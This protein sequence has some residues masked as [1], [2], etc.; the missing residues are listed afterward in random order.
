MLKISV[1][2]PF[3][4]RVDWLAEAV[5]SVLQQEY[6]HI[7][8]IVINDGSPEDVSE[9]LQRY[10]DK[11]R[12]EKKENGGPSTARNRGIEMATGD[13]IAFL[14]S[15]DIWL[16]NKLSV[17]VS[18][19]VAHD[20]TW[21]YCGYSTFG[22]GN[23]KKYDMTNENCANMQRYCVPYIATPCVMIRREYL[24]KHPECRFNPKLRYGQD[25]YMWLTMNAD[26]SILAIPEN[27]VKVR[28]RGTNAAK[29]ARVQLQAR[30][31]IWK[32]RKLEK[33]KLIKKF[34]ISLL[35]A[36]ASELCIF[37]SFIVTKMSQVIKSEEILEFVSKIFFVLPWFIF[38]VDRLI[39]KR[40]SISC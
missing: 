37:G 24:D 29:R 1:V 10:G 12:Y 17:Q 39:S 26:K 4:E 13:Y 20:A 5:E 11:I 3:Y 27:M 30:G 33:D 34:N 2:I 31:S 16:P 23:S 25:V 19:M 21:S 28:M 15:D 36:G 8:I 7:E 32:F 35:F 6:S 22:V 14:D 18:A 9:F 40:K 38:K